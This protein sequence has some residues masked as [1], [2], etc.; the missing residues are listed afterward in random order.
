MATIP[1][2]RTCNDG[3][4]AHATP[5]FFLSVCPFMVHD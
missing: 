5:L 2:E 3:C 4:A 1:R